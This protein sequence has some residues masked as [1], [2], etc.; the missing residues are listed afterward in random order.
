MVYVVVLLPFTDV[1]SISIAV[2]PADSFTVSTGLPSFIA[3]FMPASSTLAFKTTEVRF[4]GK[5]Q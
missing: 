1:T 3:T 2:R 4:E 5:S